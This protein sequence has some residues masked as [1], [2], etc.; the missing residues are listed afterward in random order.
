VNREP[1]LDDL[2][3]T[4]VTGT[5]RQRLQQ[6]HEMLL[7]AGPP[8]EISAELEA[9]PTLGMTLGRQQQHQR[10]KVKRRAMML[11]AAAITVALVF[12]AGYASRGGGKS[13][14]TSAVIAQGFRGT[15]LAP[16]AQGTLEVWSS[17]DGNNWPMTLTVVGLKQL[18]P[19][20]NYD[21]YLVR[22]GKPWGS[23][24]SFRVGGNA[25]N[26]VTVTLSAP[27]T[28]HKGDTWVVTRPGAG[29]SEPGQ[30]VL[31]PTKSV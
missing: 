17:Q 20:T 11:L 30:T 25:Q 29:G 5:E 22:N 12:I 1:N 21:V 4:E 3:G 15:S 8:P 18:P 13:G 19:H 6:V 24:G 23:C 27:Y 16:H 31:R 14:V 28:L 10:R 26:P 7:E 2:V 9:G